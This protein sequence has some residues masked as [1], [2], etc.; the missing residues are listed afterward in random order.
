MM[1]QPGMMQQQQMMQPGM[2]QMAMGNP[3]MP[4]GMPMFN[5][6]MPM[7]MPGYPGM[8]PNMSPGGMANMMKHPMMY[9]GMVQGQGYPHQPGAAGIMSGWNNNA[10]N[11]AAYPSPPAGAAAAK[12]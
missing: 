4:M 10:Y 12:F 11:S 7:G 5:P 2:G 3:A 8:A 6:A 1:M 9:P